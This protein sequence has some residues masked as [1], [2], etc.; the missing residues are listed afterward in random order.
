[1]IL[2]SAL[3]TSPLF[4][5][6]ALMC[7][8]FPVHPQAARDAA[9]KTKKACLESLREMPSRDTLLAVAVFVAPSRNDGVSVSAARVRSF[10]RLHLFANEGR[11][12]IVWDK[13]D[14]SLF[15]PLADTDKPP[16]A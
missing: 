1:M 3:R 8:A 16:V 9:Q 12:L 2:A 5:S 10:R 6:C 14:P 15:A 4:N 7:V 11:Y 13:R